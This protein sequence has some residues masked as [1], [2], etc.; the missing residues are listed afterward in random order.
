MCFFFFFLSSHMYS[1][2]CV[3]ALEHVEAVLWP[4]ALT[5]IC[6]FLG[7]FRQT[8]GNP[9]ANAGLAELSRAVWVP[10]TRMHVSVSIFMLHPP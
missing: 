5:L 4:F 10:P 1:V 6:P 2:K 3:A 7:D 8:G 9:P